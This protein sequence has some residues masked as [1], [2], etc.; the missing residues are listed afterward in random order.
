MNLEATPDQS[1]SGKYGHLEADRQV[2]LNRAW[3]CSELTVPSLLPR[4]G[5]VDQE[6]PC[7]FQNVGAQGLNNL[8]S[9]TLVTLFPPNTPFF[10]MKMGDHL[11]KEMEDESGAEAAKNL[12]TQID[13]AFG[14]MENTVQSEIEDSGDRVGMFEALKHLYV[15]GNVLIYR[16]KE[17]LRVFHLNRYVVRRDPMGNVLE[18]V[19]KE[20]IDKITLPLELQNEIAAEAKPDQK[21]KSTITMYT[22][23]QRKQ[24]EWTVQQEVA[25]K[26]IERTKGHY[27]LDQS[28][29]IP[30]RFT[31]IDGENYGR[32]Y[33]E[34]YLG[35]FRSLEN[36]TAALVQGTA[37]AAKVI[38]LVK[39]NSSTKVKVLAEAP[40]GAIRSGN[41]ED[42]T[43]LHLDKAQDF[44][45]AVNLAAQFEARLKA[46]F[47]I[48]A[49][50]QAERVTAEEIRADAQELEETLGG[51]YSVLS[52]ELQLPYIRVVL[53]G[54]Q[55]RGRLPRL[56]KGSARPTIVT[57]LEGLGR[58][59]DRNKL[60]G[61]LKTLQETI[62]PQIAQIYVNYSEVITRLAT[63]DGI[64]TKGLIKTDEEVAASQQQQ[65]QQQMVEKLGPSA[66]TAGAGIAKEG[67]KQNGQ[68]AQD[69]GQPQQ[70]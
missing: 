27:P 38:F 28:P 69:S 4:N 62:T 34:E 6:L 57:G 10:K 11:A 33:V 59:Q 44:Q 14:V 7:P 41:A 30:L 58:G 35:D 13:K 43:V 23:I 49:Q 2:Y 12:K 9:K 42:V 3:E 22:L 24:T 68:A 26:V 31:K 21:G 39:P 60:V 5:I 25:G 63:A 17:G 32:G 56:P 29:W 67:M 51:F 54:L 40:N 15:A 70:Q 18:I 36:L 64:D 20:E 37:A 52:I 48:R 8:S 53:A 46:A 55:R 61:F 66:L 65:Q 45:T 19:V 16:S 47:M 50:R 1:A